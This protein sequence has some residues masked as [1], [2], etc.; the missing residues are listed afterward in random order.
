MRVSIEK[1]GIEEIETDAIALYVFEDGYDASLRLLDGICGRMLISTMERRGFKGKKDEVFSA[2][3]M[4]KGETKLVLVGGLGKKSEFRIERIMRTSAALAKA[5]R[6]AG[7]KSLSIILNI[8]GTLEP[9]DIVR[10]SVESVLLSLYKFERY[11]KEKEEKQLGW[12]VFI[13]D[14][15]G[16]KEQES[17]RKAR[18]VAE[19]V[20]FVRDIVNTPAN[21]ATPSRIAEIAQN[22]AKEHGLRINVLTEADMK[23]LGMNA[24]VGVAKGSREK[25]RMV[26]L[27]YNPNAKKTVV[28]VGKGIT[29]DSGGISLKTGKD[30]EKMKYDKSGAIVVLGAVK[31]AAT[32]GLPI[33][34]VGIM[35]LTENMPGGSAQKPGDVVRAMNGKTIE[36]ANTDAEGRLI[37]ADALSY[38]QRYK[39]DA[40]IDIATL[41]G[42]C[43]IA[44]GSA[45]CG[46]MGND[47]ELINKILAAGEKCGEK[48]WQLPLWDEYREMIKSDIADVRNIG[49]ER[50][51]AG[52]IVGAAFLENFVSYSWAHLDIAGTA[53][54]DKENLFGTKGATGFGVRLLVR[55][56]ENM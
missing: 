40:V 47:Q 26:V 22:V 1:K 19:C 46:V 34:V 54:S 48:A 30:I 2:N 20:N 15:L 24:L 13:T 28:L 32:L 12:V 17:F 37:L 52:A 50:G 3:V 56:L 25:P 7:A 45:A 51:E 33:R 11:K 44:L 10:A 4:I 35:P 29:F 41:T 21:E 39:P 6:N 38:A 14:M 55:L 23:K 27:D 36:I 8:E 9:E 42:A 18:I 5:C 43:V 53:W 16:A 49:S 31:C